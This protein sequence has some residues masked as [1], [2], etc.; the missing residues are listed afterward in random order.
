MNRL[1][2]RARLTLPFAVAMAV[3]LVG[4]GALV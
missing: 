2:I 4:L 3:V 1:P